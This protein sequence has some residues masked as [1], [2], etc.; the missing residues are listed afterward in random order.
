MWMKFFPNPESAVNMMPEPPEDSKD[1]M[2]IK[3]KGQTA[4]PQGPATASCRHI[5]KTVVSGESG[6]GCLRTFYP[7]RKS[8]RCLWF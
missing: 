6:D 5:G 8:K 7:E 2:V 4:D 3:V 1:Y